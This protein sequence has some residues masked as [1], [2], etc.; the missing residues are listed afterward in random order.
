MTEVLHGSGRDIFDP[1]AALPPA[2]DLANQVRRSFSNLPETAWAD[3]PYMT[4]TQ[5]GTTKYQQLADLLHALKRNIGDVVQNLKHNAETESCLLQRSKAAIRILTK[6]IPGC[7]DFLACHALN[8]L[9]DVMPTADSLVFFSPTHMTICG[10]GA[11]KALDHLFPKRMRRR[12]TCQETLRACVTDL[13]RHVFESGYAGGWRQHSVANIE[14]CLCEW[15]KWRLAVFW[16]A[17]AVGLSN[18]SDGQR[19]RRCRRVKA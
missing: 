19:P 5:R 3:W 7:G 13:Q 8:V 1:T 14:H 12:T 9:S 6:H 18:R 16:K 11:I 15:I 2:R 10:N 17:A 4:L